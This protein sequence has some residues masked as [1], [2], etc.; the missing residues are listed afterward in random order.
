MSAGDKASTLT[1]AW[2]NELLGTVFDYDF[3][4]AIN[5]VSG[6]ILLAWHKDHWTA[7]GVAKGRHSLSARLTQVGSLAPWR[8]TV[9][10][11]P[12]QDHEKVEF[13]NEL[14]QFRE[15]SQGPWLICGDFN[16]IYQAHDKNNDR[17]DRRNMRRFW[18]FINRAQL[19]EIEL[20]GS[21]F[22]WSSERER[23]TLERIDR[24]LASVDWFVAHPYHYVRPLSTDCSD[25]CP[26]PLL[27]DTVA[28]ARRSGR[29]YLASWMLS[30]WRGHARCQTQTRSGSLT[31]S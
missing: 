2:A 25:H 22:T 1:A 5:N 29:N 6:G 11:G 26:L 31:S 3:V 21:C 17:L 23:P 28:G 8:I 9:V 18:A 4:P 20:T 30:P 7:D 24:F 16:M 15:G 14:L 27:L 13:L 19:Q 10:Y 12:Q